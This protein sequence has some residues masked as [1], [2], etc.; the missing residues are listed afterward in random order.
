MNNTLTKLA[1]YLSKQ[2]FK[3]TGGDD[4]EDVLWV[5][6]GLPHHDTAPLFYINFHEETGVLIINAG[7]MI[8]YNKAGASVM[9]CINFF[10]AD[11][12]NFNCKVFIDR[13]GELVVN[14]SSI[15]SGDMLPEKIVDRI[16]LTVR[17]I[18]RHFGNFEEAFPKA[19]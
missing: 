6:I 11:P 7:R 1:E 13:S 16:D 10:N 12:E 4:N 3:C 9:D 8:K 19:E 5:P 17:A 18:D 15:L 14:N 2:N